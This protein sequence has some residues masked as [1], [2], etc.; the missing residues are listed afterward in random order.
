MVWPKLLCPNLI[1]TDQLPDEQKMKSHVYYHQVVLDVD[2]SIRRFPP[3]IREAQ[4]LSM[5]DQ[6]VRLIMRI[7]IRNPSLHYYQ[8]FHDICVT[9]LI[10]LGEDDA[11]F[12]MNNLVNSHLHRFMEKTTDSVAFIL[13]LIPLLVHRK[14]PIL[15]EFLEKSEV[16]NIYGL[17]WVLTWFGHSLNSYRQLGRLFDLFIVNHELFCVY[18]VAAIVLHKR[19][20]ILELDCCLSG[21]YPYLNKLVEREEQ[22]LPFETLIQNAR[23]IMDQFPPESLYKEQAKR[24]RHKQHLDQLH[25]KQISNLPT[26]TPFDRKFV[27]AAS[28]FAASAAIYVIAKNYSP[29]SNF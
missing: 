19:D 9:F 27:L 1:T 29:A 28:V 17:S 20:E 8:G 21:V 4:R 14:D 7:L 24:V 6:L 13:E 11:F 23:S 22:R 12:A 26:S 5:Q 2:R 18:L 16:G 10:I 15:F 25:R 3:S